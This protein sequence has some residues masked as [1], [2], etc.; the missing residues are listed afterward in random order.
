M[1]F[2]YF[3]HDAAGKLQLLTMPTIRPSLVVNVDE[4]TRVRLSKCAGFTVGFIL[5]RGRPQLALGGD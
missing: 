5:G 2:T 3:T 1:P 4:R